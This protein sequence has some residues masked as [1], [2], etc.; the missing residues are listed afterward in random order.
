ML[1]DWAI[2][3]AVVAGLAFLISKQM[4]KK[5]PITKP[6]LWSL[7]IVVFI[8]NSV[9]MAILKQMRYE[10]MSEAIGSSIHPTNPLDIGGATAMAILFYSVLKSQGKPVEPEKHDE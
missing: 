4:F 6:I 1:L 9:I 8:V 10:A 7:T 3:G 5:K 2:Y